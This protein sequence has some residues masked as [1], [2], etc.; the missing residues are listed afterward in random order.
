MDKQSAIDMIT[1]LKEEGTNAILRITAHHSTE[2]IWHVDEV[3]H[4]DQDFIFHENSNT[5]VDLDALL[6]IEV[7]TPL[8][9]SS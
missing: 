8:E 4:R 6:N 3:A 2:H 9:F 7:F 1:F 5:L